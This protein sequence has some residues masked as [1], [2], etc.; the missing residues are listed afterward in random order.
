M[1]DPTASKPG[2]AVVTGASGGIGYALSGLLARDGF[3][4]VLVARSADKLRRAADAW[5]ERHGVTAEIE[6]MDLATPDAA[7]RL[8]DRLDERLEAHGSFVEV[9]V[10][11]AGVA[12]FGPFADADPART[13][14]ML[15]LNMTTL[16]LLT[17]RLLPA[18]LARGRGGVLNVAST[19]AFMPGPL[20]AAYYASK[21]YVL[22]FSEALADEVQG[23]GV[24]VT[25]LCPGP[26]ETGFKR[27]AEMEDSKLFSDEADLMSAGAVA[28]AGYRGLRD[29]KAVVVPGLQNKLQA[30]APRFLPRRLVPPLV[31]RAQERSS[32]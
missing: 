1:T 7:D 32:S 31:R 27:R 24:T 20:M 21:A 14:Q 29:G 3:D 22:H 10:N 8:G 2:L 11:N 26:T 13:A 28:E 9:L 12:T 30:L 23:S 5:A 16:T 19:A 15:Q 18:M 25:A 6:P 4:L 17:R